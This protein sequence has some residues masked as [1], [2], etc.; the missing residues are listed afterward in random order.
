MCFFFLYAVGGACRINCTALLLVQSSKP[1]ISER[2]L[3]HKW[4]SR[5]PKGLWLTDIG[6]ICKDKREKS[7]CPCWKWTVPGKHR[8][9]FNGSFHPGVNNNEPV[10]HKED[11]NRIKKAGFVL[12]LFKYNNI[13][14][15]IH[16]VQTFMLVSS[17]G[18]KPFLHANA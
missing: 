9:G 7:F 5:K 14:N 12:I 13:I 16:F 6:A 17:V 18:R 2:R 11:N 1:W 8:P 3:K 15:T 4:S 10:I